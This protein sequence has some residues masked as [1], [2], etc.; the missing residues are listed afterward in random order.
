MHCKHI[1][2]TL[3][4]LFLYSTHTAQ[5]QIKIVQLSGI[6]TMSDEDDVLPFVR[7]TNLTG[8]R[9]TSSSL[10]GVYSMV[11]EPGDTIE[12]RFIGFTTARYVIPAQPRTRFITHIQKLRID[13]FYLPE[14]MVKPL[15]SKH[16]F[17]YEFV[18]KDITDDQ[19]ALAQKNTEMS[20]L[21]FIAN[22]LMKDGNEN[23]AIDQQEYID[24]F[25]TYNQVQSIP[26]YSPGA[27]A[28]F[29]EMLFNKK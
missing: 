9:T 26:I 25:R 18:Y 22:V 11:A 1:F 12:Y 16:R 7:V 20:Q 24:R 14:A 5:D 2:V 3:L 8:H 28:S 23:V 21:M 27:W 19:L 17:E 13:T 6:T 4:L 29:M 10:Q 15:P